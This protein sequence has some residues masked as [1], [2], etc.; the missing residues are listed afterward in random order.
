MAAVTAAALSLAAFGPL[1]TFAAPDEKAPGNGRG[2]RDHGHEIAKGELPAKPEK[3]RRVKAPTDDVVEVVPATAESA[4]V[5]PIHMKV[6]V[7][8]ST[9][10]EPELGA[11]TSQLDALGT[12]YDVMKMAPQPADPA[13]DRLAAEL[14]DLPLDTAINAW[15]QGVVLTDANLSYDAGGSYPSALTPTEW[16]SLRAFEDKWDIRQVAWNSWPGAEEGFGPVQGS[17]GSTVTARFTPE[18]AEVFGSYANLSAQVPIANSWVNLAPALQ[19]GDSTPLLTDGQGHALAVKRT[20]RAA[21][22][23][24]TRE[25]VT[26]T[27]AS[28]Q[29][30]LHNTVFGYGLVNWVTKGMFLGER[31]IFLGSQVDDVMLSES[32]WVDGADCRP[33]MTPYDQHPSYRNT[34]DDWQTLVSW[35][36]AKRSTPITS[37]L[38]VAIAYNGVGSDP[39]WLE[40]HFA[41]DPAEADTSDTLMPAIQETQSEFEWITHTWTHQNLDYEEY[42]KPP[43]GTPFT[44]SYDEVRAELTPNHELAIQLGLTQYSTRTI[45][46]PEVSGLRNPEAI[47]ALYD[48]GVRYVVSDTSRG[49]DE[50]NPSFN[51]GSP[52]PIDPRILMIP[53]R[54]TNLY[55]SV[56]TPDEWLS[57]DN[58]IYPTGAWGHVDAYDELL[59]REAEVILANMLRGDIDPYM[60]HGNNIREYA[61]GRSL[62]TDL[63][64]RVLD[65]YD[66]YFTLPVQTLT[67]E[68]IGQAM[69]ARA[70]FHASGA[71]GH[72]VPNQPDNSP[73]AITIGTERA[74]TV[75]VTGLLGATG[76]SYGG[77]TIAQVVLD[78]GES[79]VF[80]D[81]SSPP[82]PPPPPPS[83]NQTR[84]LE[85][86]PSELSF[87]ARRVGNQSSAVPVTVSN[88]GTGAVSLEPPLVGGDHRDDF[89][90]TS[91]TCAG[92]L[93]AGATCRVSVAFSPTAAGD[94]SARLLVVSDAANGPHQVTLTG[95]GTAPSGQVSPSYLMFGGVKRKTVSPAQT[96]TLTNAGTAPMNIKSFS[97]RGSDPRQFNFTKDCPWTLEA[98]ASCTLSVTFAPTKTGTKTAE[99]RIATNAP[100]GILRVQLSGNGT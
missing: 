55:F 93:A 81:G 100:E 68:E 7:L 1:D 33:D 69:K 91:T 51:A 6:L 89:T 4:A 97:L 95:V 13:T 40:D 78:A 86:S 60:F 50:T 57:L 18:A 76:E 80:N 39:Q 70:G 38:H 19:D 82:P 30:L 73:G 67:M 64:D 8:S 36:R 88:T 75:P 22:N 26:L 96:V 66:D 83:E 52:N 74:V 2:H 5:D 99:L 29:H 92:S 44:M 46:T 47:G 20:H 10:S 62:M 34:A 31:K 61:D 94:R 56:S 45:V 77:Q 16:E 41:D 49:G 17:T 85:V 12:P 43:P 9:G 98:G 90:I 53:R 24:V 21:D 3:P 42:P 11:I 25:S 35:Q 63:L 23:A 59:D 14:S 48:H 84:V 32:L 54:P 71:F 87:A 79:V 27:F 72:F 15:Y 28:N 37:D 65:R 58:C